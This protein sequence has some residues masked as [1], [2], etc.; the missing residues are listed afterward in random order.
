MIRRLFFL[1]FFSFS[2]L[3]EI[4]RLILNRNILQQRNLNQDI[5]NI[6]K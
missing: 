5:K 3:I 2:A 6:N 1:F 4:N